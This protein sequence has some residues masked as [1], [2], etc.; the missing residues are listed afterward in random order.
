MIL[1]VGASLIYRRGGEVT[2][3]VRGVDLTV[4]PGEMLVIAGPSGNGKTSLLYLLSALKLASEGSVSFRGVDYRQLTQA[5]LAD[6]RRREFGLVFQQYTLIPHLTALEN[7]L[8]GSSPWPWWGLRQKQRVRAIALELL[9]SLCLGDRVNRYPCELSG[10]QRQRVAIARALVK[11]P[12]VVF[13]D[14]PTAS[15]DAELA[16]VVGRLLREHTGSG[17]SVVVATHDPRLLGFADR[18]VEIHGGKIR[19]QM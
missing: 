1:A 17:S 4:R 10:G 6:L 16:G 14:E 15:L 5:R 13:A 3:A 12:S 7:V 9:D 11:N 19:A 8:V 2:Y 18:V